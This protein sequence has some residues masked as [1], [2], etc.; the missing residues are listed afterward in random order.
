M[1]IVSILPTALVNLLGPVVLSEYIL[2]V[3]NSSKLKLLSSKNQYLL[4]KS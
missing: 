2:E 4:M 1:L 3:L